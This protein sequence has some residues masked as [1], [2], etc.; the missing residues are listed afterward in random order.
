M[1]GS[2]SLILI[3]VTDYIQKRRGQA[4]LFSYEYNLLP[5]WITRLSALPLHHGGLVISYSFLVLFYSGAT[6]RFSQA[7]A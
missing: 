5:N 7:S 4:F 1:P 3:L 2:R 6:T